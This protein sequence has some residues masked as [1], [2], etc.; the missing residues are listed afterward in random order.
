[1]ERAACPYQVGNRIRYTGPTRMASDD[2]LLST[3]AMGTVISG[4]GGAWVEP[5]T[6]FRHSWHCRVRFDNGR[7]FTV[8]EMSAAK[9]ERT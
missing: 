3:G 6:G 8:A 9:F 7:E 5:D 2:V 1:L 4:G